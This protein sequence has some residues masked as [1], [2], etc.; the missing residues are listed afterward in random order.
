MPDVS[1]VTFSDLTPDR[2]LPV[3]EAQ[4]GLELT[5][6]ARP[7]PSY[8]N[9]VYELKGRDDKSWIVKFYRPGRWTTDGLNDEHLFVKDCAEREI[10][11]VCPVELVSGSTVGDMGGIAFALFPKRGGRA[12]DIEGPDAWRRVGSLLARVHLVGTSRTA[13]SRLACTPAVF[14]KFVE[15]LCT[16][17]VD[18]PYRERYRNVSMRILDAIEPLFGAAGAGRIHGDFHC[19][20]ILSRPDEGLMVIDFD[21]MMTGSPAQDMWLLMPDHYPGC[22]RE[23]ELLL[24]GYALFGEI[25]PN[26]RRMLEPLRAMRMIYFTAWCALQRQDNAFAARFPDWGT[27]AFWS[28]EIGS[29][30]EQFGFVTDSLE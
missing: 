5:A 12:F 24:D 28:R 10:P 21:D 29:L 3:I 8:V 20:N 25:D 9:R 4:A 1:G 7:L 22:G 13:E 6:L 27:A 23:F 18:E 19:G 16:T 14:R 11:V 26:W 17:V 15:R 2:F 30:Q